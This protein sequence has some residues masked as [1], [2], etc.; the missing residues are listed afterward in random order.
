MLSIIIPAHNEAEH[1]DACLQSVLA[2]RGPEVAQIL[3]VANG[4]DDDTVARAQ[5]HIASATARGW[6]LEVLDMPA[7]GKPGALNQG[8]HFAKFDMRAYLDA[9]VTVDPTCLRKSVR[10]WT[11]RSRAMPAAKCGWPT[12]KARLRAPMPE[13]TAKCLSF[14]RACL[15]LGSLR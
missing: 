11:R 6:R 13:F 10:L 14:P 1:I 4:C 8:D 7:I 9:D 15:A 3:V 12:P 2:S 5:A